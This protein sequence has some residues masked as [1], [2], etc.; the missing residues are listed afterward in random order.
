VERSN[1]TSKRDAAIHEQRY[2][3]AANAANSNNNNSSLVELELTTPIRYAAGDAVEAWLNQL[4]CLDSSS[5]A[6]STSLRGGAPAP[7]DCEL[8]AVDRDALFS[9]HT[10]SEAFLQ[11]V[12]G[13]YTSAHYKNTP[14]DLQLL[15]DAPA[16]ALFVLLSPH[17]ERDH[18]N[19]LPDVL[20][21]LQVAL[22]GRVSRK[23]VEAQL[24]RGHRSAGDLIPWTVAQQ[25]GDSK[26]AQLSGARIVRVAVR[27]S[28]QGMGYGSRAVELLYRYYNGEMVSLVVNDDN[29]IDE[30]ENEEEEEDKERDS[31]SGSE[32]ED[33][34]E[35]PAAASKSGIRAETLK[36]RKELPPLLL[37]L[38]EVEAPR[39]DWIGTSFGLTLQLHKFWTRC[40]MKLLYLRQTKNDL[41]GE[42]SCIMV[43]ALPKRTG[44]DDAWLSAFVSDTRRR[45]IT[46]LGG[47]FSDIEI[48]LA[49][50]ALENL[51][52]NSRS[53][54]QQDAA[55][56]RAGSNTGKI[57]AEELDY[58]LTPHDLKRLELYGRNLCDHHL[59][60][61]LLPVAARL[62]FLGRLGPDV[63]LSSVQSA[64]LCGIGLQHKTVDSLTGELGLPSN[65]VLAMFNKAVRKISLALNGVLEEKEK[66]ALLGGKNR[67]KAEQAVEKMR[68]VSRKTLEEDAKDMAKEAMDS[69][70]ASQEVALPPEIAEN[71]ELMQY[72]VKGSK[73]QWD[74]ALDGKDLDTD[75]PATVSI[76]SVREKRKALDEEDFEREATNDKITPPKSGGKKKKGKSSKKK[77]SRH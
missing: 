42:H 76:H 38:T 3:A 17:A 52:P 4:L 59:V 5:A 68:D 73:E 33:D 28:V 54:L 58:F 14:N 27:P 49:L 6:A 31:S 65:Q 26:F 35:I 1:T 2:A 55:M 60:T 64:L 62:Y 43:R 47:C 46:L 32:D 15:S 18:S 16:H 34:E 24:A 8:Y 30:E 51:T 11:K 77:K 75:G 56:E 48:R 44:V 10:L 20:C 9:Y 50:S 29:D 67:K 71:P 7:G 74:K 22:E 66:Q 37:P 36:P 63:T 45:L 41:T 57:T 40:G 70:N 21:V 69:F 13:L 53:Q 12:M 61:D 19:A 25:F 39:L 23:A 72:V